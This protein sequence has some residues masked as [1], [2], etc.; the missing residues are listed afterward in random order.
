M[1]TKQN[2]G[3]QA[4]VIGLFIFLILM[5]VG[6][7]LVNNARKTSVARAEK[8]EKDKTEAR[9]A[10]SSAQSE[11]NSFKQWMGFGEAD[12]FQ[13][14]QESFQ[15]DMTQWGSTFEEQNRAYRTILESLYKENQTAALNEATAKQNAKDLKEQLLALKKEMQ[16]QQANY[17]RSLDQIQQDAASEKNKLDRKY[18][19]VVEQKN[20]LASKLSDSRGMLDNLRDESDAKVQELA[21]QVENFRTKNEVL[22]ATQVEEDPF[23]QPADGKIAWVNQGQRTVWIN[24]GSDDGIR[25]Q[26][27][28]SV[29]GADENDALSA[30]KKGS[31]EVT[32]VL[33]DRLAE[34]RITSDEVT[35]PLM[36][37]DQIYSQVWSPG[38][39]VGFGII[40]V[41]DLDGDGAEDLDTLK[42]I[43]TA[44]G[45]TIVTAPDTGGELNVKT[46]FLIA[47][48]DPSAEGKEDYLQHWRSNSDDAAALGI[49]V[50][51]VES[52]LEL[53]GWQPRKGATGIGASARPGELKL[54]PDKG[55]QRSRLST[56]REF[57][58]RRIPPPRF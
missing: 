6:L 16:D 53:M 48:D 38:R 37:G 39:E 46:R 31:I 52:F 27:T 17:K 45:G 32:R 51:Q 24:L 33:N 20:E 22:Q 36:G 21:K 57:F 34:A 54:G 19:E 3:L 25:P 26:V 49:E 5:T 10:A 18:A 9:N 42:R 8:A 43:V 13:T 58:R 47:G 28:F 30:R 12:N 40:G 11:A 23:S 29:Y 41:V 50:I 14:L 2:Q 4:L 56:D 35:R 15:E 1:A 44:N 7:V 55:G